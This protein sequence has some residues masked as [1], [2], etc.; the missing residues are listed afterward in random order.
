MNF[1]S[2]SDQ[3]LKFVEES[4]YH[5]ALNIALSGLNECQGNNDR[6]CVDKFLSLIKGVSF[7]LAQEFGSKEY[8]DQGQRQELSCFVCGATEG[9]AELVA[10]AKGAVCRSC[11]ETIYK[12]FND[13]A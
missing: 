13:K 3:I 1:K 8:L 2:Y 6:L 12:H 10:A 5:A 9:Q 4:N 11:A 7:M